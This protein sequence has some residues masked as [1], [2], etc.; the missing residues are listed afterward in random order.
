MNT[1][2]VQSSKKI[3]TEFQN[4]LKILSNKFDILMSKNMK[5]ILEQQIITFKHQ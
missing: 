5:N 2:A 3:N 4:K 1:Q